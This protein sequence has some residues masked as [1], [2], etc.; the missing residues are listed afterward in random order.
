MT[1]I[2]TAALVLT[3]LIFGPLAMLM[4]AWMLFLIRLTVRQAIIVTR[5]ELRIW[6]W[7]RAR[8]A[9]AT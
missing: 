4:V 7:R 5:T 8:D 6:R 1:G 2:R 3:A 9:A